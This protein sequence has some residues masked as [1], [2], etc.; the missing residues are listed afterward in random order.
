[1]TGSIGTANFFDDGWYLTPVRKSSQ[2]LCPKFSVIIK[3]HLNI[4]FIV[5]LFKMQT[6]SV[7]NYMDYI[8]S[9]YIELLEK[10]CARG[11]E[12]LENTKKRVLS[13]HFT[14]DSRS[15]CRL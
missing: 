9:K 8:F 10:N 7:A 12:N 15:G 6:G 2:K 4:K 14:S 3:L 13:E 5:G 11:L 1:M